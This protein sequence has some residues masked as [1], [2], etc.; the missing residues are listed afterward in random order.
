MTLQALRSDSEKYFAHVITGDDSCVCYHSESPAMFG[1]GRDDVIPGM[2]Q[3]IDLKGTM[4]II[5][6]TGT[7]LLKLIL[8]PQE[9]RCNQRYLI[10][11][12][13][14]GINE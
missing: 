14:D 9:Q 12:I 6:F 1:H 13:P 11:D 10:N 8:L 3:T 5:F 4:I 7:R 2:S